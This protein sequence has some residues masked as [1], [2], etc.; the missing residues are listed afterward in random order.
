[1]RSFLA[2]LATV[3]VIGI[4][5]LLFPYTGLYNVSAA[6]GHTGFTRWYLHTL[7]E[8]S[9]AAHAAGVEVPTAYADTAQVRRGALAYRQ[10][11]QTCHGAPGHERSVTGQGMTPMPPS[12]SEEA[13]EWKP[14][15]VYWILDQGLKMAGMPAYG[16]THTPAELWEIVAFVEQLPTMTPEQYEAL[17]PSATPTPPDSSGAGQV[18]VHSD[19]HAHVH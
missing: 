6:S 13:D 11:C 8:H 9:I 17:T 3:A 7:T 18:H 16:K 2:V 4:G 19:G 15:E 10:M 12:L 5:A 14:N 1:M